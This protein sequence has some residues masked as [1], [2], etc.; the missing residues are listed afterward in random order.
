MMEHRAASSSRSSSL[1]FASPPTSVTSLWCH[2]RSQVWTVAAGVG[3]EDA[4]HLP[5]LVVVADTVVDPVGGP[6]SRGC[7]GLTRLMG[8]G[9]GLRKELERP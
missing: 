6:S 8:R 7:P 9:L 5:I 4:G 2:H 3:G 1:L